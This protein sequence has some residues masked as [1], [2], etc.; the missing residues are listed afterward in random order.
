MSMKNVRNNTQIVTVAMFK[1][2]ARWLYEMLIKW[3][4]NIKKCFSKIFI[5]LI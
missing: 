5:N 1:F 2:F 3:M 4:C